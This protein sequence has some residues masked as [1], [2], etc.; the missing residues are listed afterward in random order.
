VSL[1]A[2]LAGSSTRTQDSC[3]VAGPES[4]PCPSDHGLMLMCCAVVLMLN[5]FFLIYTTILVPVQICLWNY[6]DPCNKFPTL[7]FDVI[8]DAFFMV[9][10]SYGNDFIICRA[11]LFRIISF[12]IDTARNMLHTTSYALLPLLNHISALSP[13]QCHYSP[14][15]SSAV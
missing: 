8:V 7:Y 15:F 12:L 14:L 10:L 11:P 9:D 5:A 3:K 1:F 4:D 2:R 13:P 6:E